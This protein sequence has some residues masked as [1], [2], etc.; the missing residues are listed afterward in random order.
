MYVHK[1]KKEVANFYYK[2]GTPKIGIVKGADD[3]NYYVSNITSTSSGTNVY[4]VA[5]VG[6]A[7]IG[8]GVS[9]EDAGLESVGLEFNLEDKTTGETY[10]EDLS[11]EQMSALLPSLEEINGSITLYFGVTMY[12]I[13]EQDLGKI[14]AT[15][16]LDGVAVSAE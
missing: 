12:R 16:R 7:T 8:G 13:P 2:V 15:P 4:S 14:K 6:K 3:T 10:F 5:F 11:E 1:Q 9:F